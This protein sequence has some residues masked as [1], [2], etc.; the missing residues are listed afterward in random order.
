LATLLSAG[1]LEPLLWPV[2]VITVLM[3]PDASKHWAVREHC[4]EPIVR[5]G[6]AAVRQEVRTRLT[7]AF[8]EHSG[9]ASNQGAL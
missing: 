5:H 4:W 3:C 9:F 1:D 2:R 6:K 7:E 8:P